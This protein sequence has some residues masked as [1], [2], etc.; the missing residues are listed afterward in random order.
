MV[1]AEKYLSKINCFDLTFALN[2]LN[3]ICFNKQSKPCN[4]TEKQLF[5]PAT[6]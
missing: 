2:Y 4:N 5:L 6:R 3:S 1:K